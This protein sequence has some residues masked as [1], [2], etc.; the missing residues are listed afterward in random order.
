M[1]SGRGPGHGVLRQ[2]RR[3]RKNGLAVPP[4]AMW[5]CMLE[6]KEHQPEHLGRPSGATAP[7]VLL[8]AGARIRQLERLVSGVLRLMRASMQS[9]SGQHTTDACRLRL[10]VGRQVLASSDHPHSP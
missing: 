2:G 3:E 10:A 6:L 9:A 5:P 8:E 4:I 1:G 7:L